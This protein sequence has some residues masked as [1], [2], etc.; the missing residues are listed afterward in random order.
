M[1]SNFYK[2]KNILVTGGTGFIGS[3]I[4]EALVKA[5]A[6]VTVFS[7]TTNLKNLESVKDKIRF[8][9]GNTQ[10]FEACLVAT[11]EKEIV[12]HLAA[13]ISAPDSF[14]QASECHKTNILGTAN[15]LEAAKECGVK[16]VI[17]SSSAAVYGNRDTICIESVDCYPESPYGYSKLIGEKLCQEYSACFGLKTLCLRYFNVFGKKQNPNGPYAAVVSKFKELMSTNKPITIFGDGQQT[18]DFIAVEKVAEANIKLAMLEEN[19]NGQPVNIASGKSINLLELIEQLKTEF[20]NYREQPIFKPARIG[21]PKRSRADNSK[22][23]LLLKS[24]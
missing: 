17:F 2:G 13:F 15:I 3:Y 23:D 4:T 11:K 1:L 5:G 19:L 6:N 9:K 12:F 18:R 16:K 21:D 10:D 22:L 20:P 14:N 7:R 24:I 8:L